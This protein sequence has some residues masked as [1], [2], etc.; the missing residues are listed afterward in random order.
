MFIETHHISK[1]FEG[2]TVLS[3]IS[4]TIKKGE[5]IGIVGANGSGKTT[6]LKILAG[7]EEPDDGHVSITK[8]A[9]IGYVPQAPDYDDTQTVADILAPFV[10]EWETHRIDK[11]LDT[12]GIFECKEKPFDTLSSG[13]KTRVYLARVIVEE[14]D[15]L[16]LDE[17][18]NHL[19]VEALEWL[20]KYLKSYRGTICVVSHDRVFLD[21]VTDRIFE[22][23]AGIL[24]EYGGNYSFYKE[25]RTIESE[26]YVRAYEAQQKNIKRLKTTAREVKADAERTDADRKQTRDNDKYATTF[27]ANRAS[28]KKSSAAKSIEQRL[29]MIDELE[30]P[31]ADQKLK[32][33]FTPHNVGSQVMVKCED[34]TYATPETEV[35]SDVSFTIERGARVVLSG[36]NGAGK[37]T[38]IKLMLGK[39]KPQSGVISLGK[40]TKVGYLS[41]EH[42]SLQSSH[43]VLS[44]LTEKTGIDK[45]LAHRLLAWLLVPHDKMNQPVNTLSRGEQS[46]VLLSEIIASG[47]NFII[48]DEPTNHLDIAAREAVEA[49][50]CEYQGTLLVVSHDR[51]F[52]EAIGSTRRLH[53]QGGT[54]KQV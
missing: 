16:L 10:R 35:L 42:E 14:R 47:A 31:E 41:Q 33:L 1:N 27:F 26:A 54:L 17:P 7:I 3:D 2:H 21:S 34:V 6:L 15:I 40:S 5:R 50:L 4:F 48:L 49:A 30:K 37:T 44:E 8:G 22:L 46:K 38:L 52:V 32:L 53:L 36:P 11:A 18:T 12:L 25:Q 9:T 45:T 19:D 29:E 39:L 24:K 23:S 51:Y 20:E 28:K 43:T 13:Q